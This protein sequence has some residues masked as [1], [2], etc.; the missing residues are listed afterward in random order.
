MGFFLIGATSEDPIVLSDDGDTSSATEIAERKGPP[1]NEVINTGIADDYFSDHAKDDGALIE[2]MDKYDVSGTDSEI[3]KPTLLNSLRKA[4][5][6]GDTENSDAELLSSVFEYEATSLSSVSDNLG[7][8]VKTETFE[9]NTDRSSVR[10]VNSYFK[11]RFVPNIKTEKIDSH[12]AIETFESN[13]TSFS[14]RPV[15]SSAVKTSILDSCALEVKV[16]DVTQSDTVLFPEMMDSEPKDHDGN[17]SSGNKEENEG[18]DVLPNEQVIPE[19]THRKE[20]KT[21]ASISKQL[22]HDAFVDN[23]MNVWD[24]Y[25]GYSELFWNS[26]DNALASIDDDLEELYGTQKLTGEDRRA[27]FSSRNDTE[28]ADD[29]PLGQSY[30]NHLNEAHPSEH[31]EAISL[32]A[33]KRVTFRDDT[34][35]RDDT[36]PYH[37]EASSVRP[38]VSTASKP[39]DEI[40]KI[41]LTEDEFF[42]EI[43]GWNVE[44]LGKSSELPWKLTAVPVPEKTGFDSMDQYYDTF[45][46]L[47]FMEIWAQV[48]HFLIGL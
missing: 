14:E 4:D 39:A 29:E 40:P 15:R 38:S 16:E 18:D 10:P 17:E 36:R 23:G 46:P 41:T 44:H 22:E 19:S 48:Q 27:I 45:K 12:L 47:L 28:E 9:S 31:T 2:M 33:A 1:S 20:D 8:K 3:Q 21:L 42:H 11:T 13:S 32:K 34:M 30:N 37:A 43:L 5:V 26:Q 24:D 7:P 6:S 25:C 35:F